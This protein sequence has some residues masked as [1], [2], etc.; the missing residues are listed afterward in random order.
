M[1]ML[2]AVAGRI[3]GV[4]LSPEMVLAVV[5]VV[6]LA[7][8]L[9]RFLSAFA[10]AAAALVLIQV[11]VVSGMHNRSP[12]DYSPASVFAAV[13]ALL[14]WSLIGLGIKAIIQKRRRPN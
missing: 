1:E 4:S 13:A 7:T 14:L 8:S 5:V 10:M 6:R 2:A 9:K 12:A 3:V 11:F